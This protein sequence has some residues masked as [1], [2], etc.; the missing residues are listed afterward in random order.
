MSWDRLEVSKIPISFI[1]FATLVANYTE[2]N[3]EYWIMDCGKLVLPMVLDRLS[4][5]QLDLRPKHGTAA[6]AGPQ[7]S[8]FRDLGSDYS[9]IASV[10]YPVDETCNTSP[11]V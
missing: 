10:R 8:T 2:Y 6:S 11:T 7:C 3:T 1:R 4:P 9:A 5:S